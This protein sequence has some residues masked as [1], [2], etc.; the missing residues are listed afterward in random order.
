[1]RSSNELKLKAGTIFVKTVGYDMNVS[2]TEKIIANWAEQTIHVLT[3]AITQTADHILITDKEGIIQYVNPAF[4]KTTGFLKQEVFG[5]TP[6]ILKSGLHGEEYYKALWST[7]LSGEVFRATT[8]NKKK[9]GFLYYADQTITPIKNENNQITHFV[10]VWKDI[11]E[12]IEYEEKLKKLNEHIVFEKYKLEQI[13]NF[14]EKVSAI[15]D[16]NK[17]IDFI[18]TKACDILNSKRCSLM[19]IDETLQE[20]CIKGSA[21][22]NERFTR[23]NIKVGELIAGFVIQEAKSILVENIET[24]KRFA[25][26]NRTGY[27]S[28]SFISVPICLDHK[29][30]GV[31]NVTDKNPATS[32]IFTQLDLKILTAI[33]RQAAV[34]IENAQIYKELNYLT[35]TDAMTDLYNYRYFTKSLENE[36]NRTKRFPWT[37]SLMMIDIDHFKS[38][39]DSFGHLQGDFLLR[40][41]GRMIQSNLREV[42]IVCR[43]AG[44]EF[45]V[46]LPGTDVS[47]ARFIAEKI[48]G[49]VMKLECKRAMTFSVG[50]TEYVKGMSRYEL[51]SRVDRALYQ[52][53]QTGRNKVCICG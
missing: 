44:D 3:A 16:I 26:P 45:V 39:N 2:L 37:F 53:K 50:V 10:S 48:R 17:L 49:K 24:D 5:K 46:I 13:L 43:Y 38:Y 52:A 29:M 25:R 35:I 23:K 9:D 8:I 22:L 18:I 14:D 1:M 12:R 15:K 4:E 19:L 7:I 34:V 40:E 28:K 21:G 6:S 11:T 41:V 33:V 27:E 42:D 51:I 31:V 47:R 36:I 30:I 20:L 32:N